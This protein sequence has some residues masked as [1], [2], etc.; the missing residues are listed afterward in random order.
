MWK[1]L[2]EMF[3]GLP[4]LRWPPWARF[5]LSTV[6][7]G[8]SRAK[9]TARLALAPEWG[10]TLACLQPNSWQARCLASSSVTSTAAQPP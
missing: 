4:W 3:T 6:S 7:P 9:N 5:M 2:P 1:Y 10:W 8:C